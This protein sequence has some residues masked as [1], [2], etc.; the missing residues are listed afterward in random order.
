MTTRQSLGRRG[1]QI[2]A[3]YLSAQDYTIIARN[4]KVGREE[5]DIITR[6]NGWVV[7]AEVKTRNYNNLND[8]LIS[9]RQLIRLRRALTKYAVINNLDFER[10][11]LDLI[12]I[13]V[14]KDKKTASLK[15]YPDI[16]N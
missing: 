1:E 4:L 3:A 13:S 11:R 16:L 9:Q 5:L 14:A 10:L 7:F 15:H 6:K 8:N 12:L 2:A